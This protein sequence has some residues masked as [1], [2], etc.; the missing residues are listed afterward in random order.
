MN[1]RESLRSQNLI[2]AYTKLL[3]FAV[4]LY[5]AAMA[6]HNDLILNFVFTL[7][8]LLSGHEAPFAFQNTTILS[9]FHRKMDFLGGFDADEYHYCEL[10]YLSILS[11]HM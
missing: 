2:A 1:I 8:L 4:E 11:Y 3:H 5:P 7:G 9:P 10:P 6:S